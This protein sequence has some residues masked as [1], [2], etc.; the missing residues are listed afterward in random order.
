[1]ENL[2]TDLQE[3]TGATSLVGAITLNIFD[4]VSSVSINGWFVLATS[5]GGLIYLYWK[6]KTQR[7]TSTLL[8][9]EIEKEKLEIKKLRDEEDL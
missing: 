6:I 4:M 9:L 5:I 2:T 7:K 1:M 8:D 3:V